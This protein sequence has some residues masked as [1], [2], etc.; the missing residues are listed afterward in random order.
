MKIKI[1]KKAIG[2]QNPC[3]IIAEAGVNHNGD[4]TMAKKLIDVAAEAKVDAVKFQTFN[5]DTLVV[6]GVKKADYQ[7]ENEKNKGSESHYEMLKRLMLPRSWHK[8]L[9][10]YAQKKGLI[11]LSTPFSFNDLDFLVGLGLLA[12]KV[13]SSDSNNIPYLKYLAKKGLPIILS[14]GMSDFSEV[15]DS[16]RAIRKAGNTKLVVLHCTTNYPTQMHEVN[17]K[18]MLVMKSK[19]GVLTGFSDHTEG[20]EA[21]I[22]AVALGASVIEKHFTI[23]R[24][25]PGPDHKASLEPREL[26]TMVRAIRNIEKALGSGIKKAFKSEAEIAKVARKSI[27]AANDIKKGVKITKEIL[28]IKRPGTG[29]PPKFF[30]KVIEKKAKRNIEKDSLIKFKDLA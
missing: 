21:S 15:K 8:R 17:L 14:T 19:L 20:I 11:F 25:L 29:I 30:S 3:F 12:I 16:V 28:V 1:G 6:R 10:K 2:Q 13:T 9:I 26:K 4:L 23:D 22:A 7:R 5:P 24:N 27:V 18:A